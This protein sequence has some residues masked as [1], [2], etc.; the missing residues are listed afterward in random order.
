MKRLV[1]LLVIG[2]TA[3][4]A[5][6][7]ELYTREDLLFLSH[8]VV[9]HEQALEMAA[10]VPSRSQRE[11]FARF[12]RYVDGGQR[13]EI[14]Q[15]KG[16]LALATD[17]G[18]QVPEHTLHGDPPMPG[19]LSKAQMA[20]L[21]AAKGAEFERLW[22]QGMIQHHEGAIAM[23]RAQQEY[24]FKAGRRPYGIDVMV[25]EILVVQRGEITKMKNWLR[26][27]PSGR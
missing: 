9:H 22:L 21:T 25:D 12:A 7:E 10:L 8:M 23:G 14:E 16:L 26:E 24:Q 2:L 4:T 6:A 3:V 19:M 5:S 18:L 27:W 20:A 11:E 15:M 13:A 1:A 17:R